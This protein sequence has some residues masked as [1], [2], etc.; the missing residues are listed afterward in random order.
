MT[1]LQNINEK[2]HL[3]VKIFRPDQKMTGKNGDYK[4]FI[5]VLIQ[6]WQDK[7]VE[8]LKINLQPHTQSHPLLGVGEDLRSEIMC[9]HV[10]TPCWARERCHPSH[11]HSWIIHSGSIAWFTGR[12]STEYWVRSADAELNP[13]HAAKTSSL[14]SRSAG[15][16]Q[17]WQLRQFTTSWFGKDIL[18][19]SRIWG[20]NDI[21]LHCH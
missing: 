19:R 17:I 14:A 2:K 12:Q 7:S 21:V 11:W 5:N 6:I 18:N 3:K 8:T 1:D 9:R 13:Q 20:G 10:W 15:W 16:A 4:I